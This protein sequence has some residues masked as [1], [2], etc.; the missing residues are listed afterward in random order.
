MLSVVVRWGGRWNHG[1]VSEASH[2]STEGRGWGGLFRP[3]AGRPAIPFAACSFHYIRAVGSLF[4]RAIHGQQCVTPR[5]RR[6]GSGAAEAARGPLSL[7]GVASLSLGVG[8]GS[9]MMLIA[10]R[11]VAGFSGWGRTWS[12]QLFNSA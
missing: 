8:G 10:G 5:V 2:S 11:G 3:V 12:S 9:A 1:S 4:G 6:G 7:P